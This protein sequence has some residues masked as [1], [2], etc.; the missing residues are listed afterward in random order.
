[1]WFLKR[2][3]SWFCHENQLVESLRLCKK[4]VT[5]LAEGSHN[6]GI[7]ARC[8]NG[9]DHVGQVLHAALLSLESL[10]QWPVKRV[11]E[12]AAN[13]FRPLAS[14]LFLPGVDFGG[15][16]NTSVLHEA[17]EE[18]GRHVD[19]SV[20]TETVDAVFPHLVLNPQAK[21]IPNLLT[22]RLQISQRCILA[23]QPAVLQVVN[24]DIAVA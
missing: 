11:V 8:R 9:F 7:L 4:R 17:R 12:N 22:F 20:N 15:C 6:C 18:V 5:Y 14:K 24:V 2:A 16:E 13:G 23:T 21:H 19:S 1:V 3:T 10:G